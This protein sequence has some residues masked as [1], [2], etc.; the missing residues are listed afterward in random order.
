MKRIISTLLS[1][2]LVLS[3]L[4]TV[5]LAEGEGQ[6]SF[7]KIQASDSLFEGESECIL[8]SDGTGFEQDAVTW[9]VEDESI[10][11]VDEPTD[12]ELIA[13]GISDPS[14]I[15]R[16]AT[17]KITGLKEGNTT[18][19]ATTDGGK[20]DTKTITVKKVV[21]VKEIKLASEMT[22]TTSGLH[23]LEYTIEPANASIQ[24]LKWESTDEAVAK[25]QYSSGRYVLYAYNNGT[26]TITATATDGSG[27][28][29]S[30][31]VNVDIKYPVTGMELTWHELTFNDWNGQQLFTNIFPNNA[32][33]QNVTWES[34]NESVAT[35][36]EVGYVRPVSK[37]SATITATTEDGGYQDTCLVTVNAPHRH[38]WSKCWDADDAGHHYHVC[39]NS[40]CE[41]SN[42]KEQWNGYG[43]HT[44]VDGKCT[45]CGMGEGNQKVQLNEVK[46]KKSRF[47]Y[48][49]SQIDFLGGEN[50]DNVLKATA[51]VGKNIIT[52]D[53]PL[54]HGDIEL[55]DKEGGDKNYT[56]P[57]KYQIRT[58]FSTGLYEF[59]AELLFEIVKVTITLPNDKE[60][61][62]FNKVRDFKTLK[63]DVYP[64]NRGVT[65]KS[66][67]PDVAIV[68]ENGNVT[69]TGNG[70]TTITATANDG[71]GAEASCNVT[72][73]VTNCAENECTFTD[74]WDSNE[75]EHWL[76]CDK[77]GRKKDAGEAH[78]YGEW[79]DDGTNHWKEC[80][81]C[82]HRK[83]EDKHTYDHLSY[84]TTSHWYECETCHTKIDE[85]AHKFGEW[86]I[87]HQATTTTPGLRYQECEDCGY[88]NEET[89]PV[90]HEHQYSDQWTSDAT[91]H[92]HACECGE[93]SDL[94]AHQFKWVIDQEAT[95]TKPGE[96]HQECTVCGYKTAP[97]TIPVTHEHQYS[98]K[99]SSDATNHWHAC[100]CGEKSAQSAHKFKWVIDRDATT[101][102]TGQKH[103]E[104][105]TCGYK[106]AA[107]TIPK[108]SAPTVTVKDSTVTVSN[109]SQTTKLDV[110]ADEDAKL[111]YKSDNKSVKV[112]KN[113]KVTISK[114][115]VGKATVTVTA[116]VNGVKTTKKV[117]ITVNPKGTTF[118]AVYNGAG[119]KLKA[120]WKRNSQVTGYQLQY[121]TNKNFTGCK[122][123]TLKS[124]QYTGSVRAGLKKN[125][126]YYVRIRTYKRVSGKTYYSDWSKVKSFKVVR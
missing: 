117:T 72:V 101:T 115:F 21:P 46:M 58:T 35:V 18:V 80:S 71:S 37:G 48:D 22:F 65:W 125:A 1:L 5:A 39:L 75:T 38:N 91:N 24:D 93:K 51:I 78:K 109:K 90:L 73:N 121:G 104:C 42:N 54:R 69:A 76:R 124:N 30:C 82:G 63:A 66:N 31:E 52:L 9:S 100:E 94:S 106:T 86:V 16:S 112:D 85:S 27:V 114:N 103:Q 89:I 14:S 45:V 32:T 118:R 2:S 36:D 98:D 120:Y 29:A 3:L 28:T 97:V 68:D 83:D 26:T 20:T 43:K 55:V 74:W 59:D 102:K 23:E 44:Y 25:V 67:D 34:D 57:G 99:W 87:D 95:A 13:A 79:Q 61:L 10:I 126:T 17:A 49:G 19:T 111:T 113:G 33:N 77:C 12:S 56:E 8:V 40:D 84:G 81:V 96:K 88:K 105:T 70:T 41:L 50:C 119:K 7:F 108:K 15:N 6:D 62:T 11:Q 107:V 116:T 110:K 60:E 122:T 4:P 92:W 47:A 64:Q 53:T 123:V